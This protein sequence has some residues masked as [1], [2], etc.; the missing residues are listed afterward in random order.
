MQIAPI[1]P[2]ETE[3]LAALRRYDL[4]DTPPETE[5]DDF[6]K[7]ASLICG[8]PIALI[9]L[10]DQDRQWFKSRV[11]MDA[12]ETPRAV[13]FCAHA[14]KGN[15]LLEIPNAPDDE[16]FCDN[17]LVAGNP[18]IRF[19]AGMPLTTPDGFNIGTLCVIDKIPRKLTPEQRDAMETLGRQLTAKMEQRLLNQKLEQAVKERT[20]ELQNH[21]G[22]MHQLVEN[23]SEGVVACDAAGKLTF[24]NK[25]AREWH[26]TD[27]REIPPEFR[28]K[29][30][31]L[32]EIDGVTPLPTDSLPL[33]R[34]LRGERVRNAELSI[35]RKGTE[36]RL[37]LASGEILYDTDGRKAG[38]VVVLH[39]ITQH[40][41]A[42]QQIMRVQRLES[43]GT[44]AGGVA[45]DL[46]NTLAPILMVTALLRKRY[47][48]SKE[49]IDEVEASAKRGADMVQQLLTFAKGADG[50]R[51]FIEPRHLL[52]EMEKIIKDTFPKSIHLKTSYGKSLHSIL[53]DAT[54]L[55]QVLLNLCVNA[56]D[57]MPK[58]GTLTLK[59]E[60]MEIAARQAGEFPE[61]K[62]GR[63]V[64]WQVTDT[65]MGIPPENLE[66]IFEPFF[67]TKG[68]DKGTGL[69]LST[70]M[71]I[72]KSH[73][74]FIR[75]ISKMGQGST[76][77][78][79][80]PFAGGDAPVTATTIYADSSFRGNGETILVVDD[81][82]GVR[83]AIR[84]VLTTLNF[85]VINAA[86]GTEAL[87][88][89]AEKRTDLHAV[90]CD[91][92]MPHMD[93]LAFV[94]AIKRMS[95]ETGI[96]ITSGSMDQREM[97]EFEKLEVDA[98]L[99]KPF[100]QEKMVESLRTVLKNRA[101]LQFQS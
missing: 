84:T 99:T 90:F 7:L 75:V 94:R 93:G 19:Y 95:P 24:F 41:K 73:E 25:A 88:Y 50:A 6:T 48:D 89:A 14:I 47:P 5:F 29:V 64:V 11:G 4:L 91:L 39:D 79:Y 28:Q 22:F 61:A 8:T 36:P 23:L 70:V 38:A 1:P 74:G 96:I 35:V 18:N 40:R 10:V 49:M 69:G 16:R 13:A 62:P 66:R 80:L 30:L 72:I 81:D 33:L 71:G 17:P 58:G 27:L 31:D 53:G 63:Y 101:E 76:F 68:P 20:E 87:I 82:A 34:L 85:Q 100:T 55:F 59:A 83:Q 67:S 46:N 56:R 98:V 37:L 65:G 21:Q 9:S 78:I 26:G 32:Y 42:E 57:A 44:L 51:L 92:R 60:T 97:N 86:D 2:N 12:H 15:E 43:I 54:Q 3:R 77:S 45:H 52:K